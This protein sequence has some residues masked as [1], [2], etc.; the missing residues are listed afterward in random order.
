M[1]RRKALLVLGSVCLIPVVGCNSKDGGFG[2]SKDQ[3]VGEAD[4]LP[5]SLRFIADDIGMGG[6]QELSNLSV[7]NGP[8]GMIEV[9]GY[10]IESEDWEIFL[11][12]DFR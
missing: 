12:K 7:R 2:V 4:N 3:V 1:N 11:G 9:N 5:T 6:L 10:L 8:F